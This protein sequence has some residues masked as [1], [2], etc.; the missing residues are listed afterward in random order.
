M[1]VM[2]S[3]VADLPLKEVIVQLSNAAEARDL[4]RAKLI[5]VELGDRADDIAGGDDVRAM[6]LQRDRLDRIARALRGY[7]A[8]GPVAVF[9]HGYL[10]DADRRLDRAR[11]R[12]LG[13][14]AAARHEREDLGVRDQVLAL[15]TEPL[16]PRDIAQSLICDPSQVSR[17]LNELIAS[18]DVVRVDRPEQAPGDGRAHWFARSQMDVSAAA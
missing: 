7:E 13:A 17:A 18:G 8:D 11:T 1:A 3:A 9:A 10:A 5:L 6:A 14:Q 16:R 12:A 15:L 2:E 4:D